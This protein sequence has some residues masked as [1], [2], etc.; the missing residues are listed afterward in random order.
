MKASA[1]RG[2]ANAWQSCGTLLALAVQTGTAT[3]NRMVAKHQFPPIA[4]SSVSSQLQLVL[5]RVHGK[6]LQCRP[7]L[8]MQMNAT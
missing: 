6:K 2:H 1:E 4:S 8:C 5:L 3:Y 7:G